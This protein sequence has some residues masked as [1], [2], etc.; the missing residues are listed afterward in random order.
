MAASLS[1]ITRKRLNEK[2]SI[3]AVQKAMEMDDRSCA[4]IYC[5]MLEHGLERLLISKMICLSSDAQNRLFFGSG[6]LAGF[7]AKIKIAQAFGIIGPRCVHDL[8]TFNDIR[9]VFAHSAHSVTF[10]NRKLKERMAGF[11][12]WGTVSMMARA[13]PNLEDSAPWEKKFF[14]TLRGR[15]SMVANTYTLSFTYAASKSRR[16]RQSAL[17]LLRS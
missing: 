2:E 15:F 10:R 14:P 1:Q 9:N 16:N 4:I 17:I 7:S 13:I 3:K 5:A 11:H 6:P 8:S 12:M